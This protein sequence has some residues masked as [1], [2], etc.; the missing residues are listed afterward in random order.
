[1]RKALRR[2]L[3]WLVP[4]LRDNVQVE[5]EAKGEVIFCKPISAEDVYKESEDLEDYL[6]K[7]DKI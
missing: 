4:E 2:F 5:E 1:M 6:N 3:L 7:I